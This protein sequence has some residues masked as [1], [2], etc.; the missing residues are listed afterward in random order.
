[1]R[2]VLAAVLLLTLAGVGVVILDLGGEETVGRDYASTTALCRE[3]ARQAMIEGDPTTFECDWDAVAEERPAM[4]LNGSY[5]VAMAGLAGRMTVLESEDEPALV[6]ISTTSETHA[7]SCIAGLE[8]TRSGDRLISRPSEAPGC[9]L[10]IALG[11]RP[12]SATVS[13]TKACGHYCGTNLALGGDFALE[14]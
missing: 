13:A 5:A 12:G 9:E 11:D 14:K 1:M 4:S 10:T 2:M 7:L 8:A 6:A 3:A